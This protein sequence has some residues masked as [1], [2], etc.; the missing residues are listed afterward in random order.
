VTESTKTKYNSREKKAK[1]VELTALGQKS[2]Y[3]AR[4]D[5]WQLTI[6]KTSQGDKDWCNS[7]I[8]EQFTMD[9][10]TGKW[11]RVMGRGSMT[12][13]RGTSL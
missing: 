7:T 1:S 11:G 6:R 9:R 3:L 5:R 4:Y 8:T 13:V 2:S 10:G 12:S